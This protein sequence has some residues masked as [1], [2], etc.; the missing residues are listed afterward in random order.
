M[1]RLAES[2]SIDT[3]DLEDLVKLSWTT[4]ESRRIIL[5]TFTS[6]VEHE[7]TVKQGQ[8][9]NYIYRED[10]WAYIV[11]NDKKE[12][13]VPFTFLA[14]LG[15]P[16]KTARVIDTGTFTKK[17]SNM[18]A[19]TFSVE[20]EETDQSVSDAADE[21]FSSTK[22]SN[23]SVTGSESIGTVQQ[24]SLVKNHLK[25]EAF[26][27]LPMFYEVFLDERTNILHKIPLPV[28]DIDKE[29]TCQTDD[30]EPT[31]AFAQ[32]K[33]MHTFVGRLLPICR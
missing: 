1:G 13:F 7:I 9:V 32:F 20:S 27:K 14:K 5:Q 15:V 4:Q 12:G 31:S 25:S 19:H 11:T 6:Y 17:N 23:E 3:I 24:Q 26:D 16:A 8:K 22:W 2:A 30:I 10:D 28:P 29:D 21:S 18:N 33:V